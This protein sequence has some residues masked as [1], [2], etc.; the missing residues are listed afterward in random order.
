MFLDCVVSEM[1]HPV[2]AV[3]ESILLRR[4]T[5][6]AIIIPVTL[7]AAINSSYEDVAP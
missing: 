2:T 7:Q 6:I 3:I 1:D 5:N 4:S